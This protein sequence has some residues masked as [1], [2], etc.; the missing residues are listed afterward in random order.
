[1]GDL[2]YECIHERRDHIA[3]ESARMTSISSQ[4][5]WARQ[6]AGAVV[7]PASA[8]LG[9]CS[10]ASGSGGSRGGRSSGGLDSSIVGKAKVALA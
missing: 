2:L 9:F 6:A 5:Y 10:L 7:G 8:N 1:M 4:S 3:L